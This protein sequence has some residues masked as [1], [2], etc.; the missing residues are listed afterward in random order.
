MGY[1]VADNMEAITMR[2]T[3]DMAI[4]NR[5]YPGQ[6]LIHHSDRGLQYCSNEYVSKANEHNLSMSMTKQ[7]DPYENALAERMN[8]T[9]KEEFCLDRTLKTK[10]LGFAAVKQAVSLYNNYRLHLSLSLETPNEQHQKTQQQEAAGFYL[11][12]LSTYFRT[13]QK[14]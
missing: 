10:Q 9:I 7:S 13:I 12:K 1:C 5:L 2:Q 6:S 11:K 14:L 3:L 8:R 4:R